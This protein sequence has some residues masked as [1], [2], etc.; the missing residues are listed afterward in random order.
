MSVFIKR[1]WDV[2]NARNVFALGI[3]VL[4]VVTL[5]SGKDI[6]V[7]PKALGAVLNLAPLWIAVGGIAGYIL[8]LIIAFL[9]DDT[10]ISVPAGHYWLFSRKFALIGAIGVPIA[11]A[12]ALV[13]I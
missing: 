11:A 4:F 13:M 8:G 7:I 12:A 10:V 3:L 2:I 9:V 6:A 1:D 5:F